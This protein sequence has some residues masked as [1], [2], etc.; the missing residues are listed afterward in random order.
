VAMYVVILF[1][2]YD[3]HSFLFVLVCV[4]VCALGRLAGVQSHPAGQITGLTLIDFVS[5]PARARLAI[6]YDGAD[7]AQ[8]F[9]SLRKL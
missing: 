8:G 7:G 2:R 9:L 5:L 4:C 3:T 6:S 1:V